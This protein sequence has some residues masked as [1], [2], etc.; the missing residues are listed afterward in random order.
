MQRKL[1]ILAV[2]LLAVGSAV[3]FGG[4]SAAAGTCP[5]TGYYWYTLSSGVSM[6]PPSNYSAYAEKGLQ[7]FCGTSSHLGYFRAAEEVWTTD[8]VQPRWSSSGLAAE[9]VIIGQTFKS[10][11]PPSTT[12]YN[13]N[14]GFYYGELF[15]PYT[16]DYYGANP[17]PWASNPV[18]N[19]TEG[20]FGTNHNLSYSYIELNAI[21]TNWTGNTDPGI[22]V[23]GH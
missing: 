2:A 14:T 22:K 4:K 7:L 1:A 15:S 17:G 6:Y 13:A 8:G 3:T 23:E 18:S 21:T 12:W 20:F 9:A 19:V 10:T 16:H 11:G 5:G